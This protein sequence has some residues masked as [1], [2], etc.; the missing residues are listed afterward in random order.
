MIF[1][2]RL[3]LISVSCFAVGTI[4]PWWSVIL[5][6]VIVSFFLPGHNFNA[7]LSGFLGVGLLWMVMA[8]KFDMESGS[9]MSNK[10]TELFKIDDP[11]LLIVG[12]GVIGALAGGFAAFT[13]N[14]FRQ[15]FIKKKK[16]SFYS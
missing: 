16:P 11:I 10:M 5:C 6:S 15:I 2:L 13:G 12:T 3:I 8:W 4:M 9:N 7:F 1:I 14:S